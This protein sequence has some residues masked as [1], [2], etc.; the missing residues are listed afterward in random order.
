MDLI[1]GENVVRFLPS[2][3]PGKNAFR[4][5][6][7]HYVDPIPGQ[8]KMSVF[9]CLAHE[10]K[11]KCPACAMSEKLHNM[12]D[13]A[14]AKRLSP[15]LK[16]L[17]NVMNRNAPEAGPKVLGFGT[18]IWQALRAIRSNPRTGGDFVN[19]TEKGFDIIIMREGEMMSTKYMVSA[20]RDCTPLCASEDEAVEV[21]ESSKDLD[22][23][24]STQLPE[25]LARFWGTAEVARLQP[26]APRQQ[27]AAAPTARQAAPTARQ[28]A[29][30]TRQ[31]APAAA[32][33]RVGAGL[34]SKVAAPVQVHPED[35]DDDFS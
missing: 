26:A 4:V 24:I 14:G 2:K 1:A 22:A 27:L 30:A 13:V 15:K 16:V 34:V 35:I 25:E 10:L 7:L 5:T 21:I 18:S 8:Q 17:A 9:S 6:Y 33:P 31:A 3:T 20:A 19:P 29:P 11:Q 32:S 28:A 23:L 12:G